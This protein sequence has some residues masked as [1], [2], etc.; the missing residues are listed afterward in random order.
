MSS[1]PITSSISHNSASFCESVILGLVIHKGCSLVNAVVFSRVFNNDV[2]ESRYG[3]NS[4]VTNIHSYFLMEYSSRVCA[5]TCG[6]EM[7][8]S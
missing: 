7:S 8:I 5:A 2:S 1:C 3:I 4:V 6:I